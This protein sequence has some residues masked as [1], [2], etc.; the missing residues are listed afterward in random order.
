MGCGSAS[1]ERHQEP[2]K[3]EEKP[4]LKEEK[5]IEAP[6]PPKEEKAPPIPPREE[7]KIIVPPKEEP[8]QVTAQVEV[9]EEKKPEALAPPPKVPEENKGN[10]GQVSNTPV[11]NKKVPDV[12]L[13]F[14]DLPEGTIKDIFE[15]AGGQGISCL[16]YCFRTCERINR[17]T[18]SRVPQYCET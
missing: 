15:I 14:P 6:A 17:K 3:L 1:S 16:F 11:V 2:S 12:E 10:I 9:K 8:K 4:K 13:F 18:F 5:K 7:K